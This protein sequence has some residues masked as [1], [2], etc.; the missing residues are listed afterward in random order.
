M[1]G[2]VSEEIRTQAQ[3]AADTATTEAA[4]YAANAKKTAADEVKDVASALRT[5]SDELRDGS[6]QERTFS[7]IAESLADASDALRDKDLGEMVGAVNDFA[8]RNPLV[9]LGG[10]TLIGFTA[11]RFA[12]ASDNSDLHTQSN[13]ENKRSMTTEC[14]G[15]AHVTGFP[16]PPV[17]T[18][19]EGDKI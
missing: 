18:H 6:P 10:A 9:F 16:T 12:K 5:A 3:K 17:T 11:T 4:N 2:S 7:Q 13:T 19:S 15:A 14:S 8:K 1:A